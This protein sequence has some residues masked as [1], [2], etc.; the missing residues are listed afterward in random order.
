MG[1]KAFNVNSW[2]N[3]PNTIHVS[4]NRL[5]NAI[6][7]FNNILDVHGH[8]RSSPTFASNDYTKSLYDKTVRI[9]VRN[10]SVSYWQGFRP[11]KSLSGVPRAYLDFW[12]AATNEN[13]TAA[14][15]NNVCYPPVPTAV[16]M[17][18]L[19]YTPR[20]LPTLFSPTQMVDMLANW[21]QGRYRPV[22]FWEINLTASN[23][24]PYGWSASYIGDESALLA[25]YG[26][27]YGVLKYAI[28]TGIKGQ[29]QTVLYNNDYDPATG[30]RDRSGIFTDTFMPMR[31]EKVGGLYDDIYVPYMAS[32]ARF[33]YYGNLGEDRMIE[34]GFPWAG[35]HYSVDDDIHFIMCSS[36]EAED[37]VFDANP[38]VNVKNSGA[39]GLLS[40]IP[41]D[42]RAYST[43]GSFMLCPKAVWEDIFAGSGMPWSYSE[44]VVKSPD[45]GGLNK[46]TPADLPKD[47]TD[48]EPGSGDNDSDKVDYPDPLYIPNAT[49]YDRYFLTPNQIPD[50]KKFLFSDTFLT[51][52]KRLW[53]NPAEYIISLCCYPFDIG[54]T[55]MSTTDTVL[56][57]GG[58]A[59]DIRATALTDNGIP[60]F[61][62]GE[63]YVDKY[64]NSYLDY[65]PYTSIDI[66]IPYI[67]VRPLNVS[68]VV[69]HTLCLGYYV[70]LNTQQVTALIGLDGS[71]SDLGNVLTQY[72]GSIGV[73]TPLSG[74]S[75]QDMIRNVVSQTTGLITG[76]GAIAGGIASGNA[77]LA[78]GGVDQV[79]NTT[80]GGQTT[81]PSY[82][83]TLSPVS[84]LFTPQTAY[85]IINRP[86]QALPSTWQAEH[87]YGAGYSGAVSEFTG[88]LQAIDVDLVRGDGMTDGE[89]TNIINLLKEGILI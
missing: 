19:D 34:S 58:V 16:N 4:S 86:R 45:D 48:D 59:S 50:V 38:W 1:D 21:Y 65:E 46:P 2:Q 7:K 60:Y 61:Y 73:Q 85:L 30:V 67:G 63:V 70:D 23:S 80:V 17:D 78:L 40:E 87:G 47:P 37:N 55:G 10:T 33:C 84:G 82:Y 57:V 81:A 27:L 69:G 13:T 42:G 44:D 54:S 89:A 53:T 26:D 83:G 6:A 31:L 18:M 8:F 9:P 68:Q 20:L 56:A 39:I 25:K 41:H 12:T 77:K 79:V 71:P 28:Y 72:I 3:S 22:H 64:Y 51:N 11:T 32:I 15:T 52:I 49:V 66:Y 36:C 75:A 74:T 43:Q 29:T 35:M 5:P 88:F 14:D 24:Y 76:V 62:G